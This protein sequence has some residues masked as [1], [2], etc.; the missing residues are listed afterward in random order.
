MVG[1]FP[2]VVLSALQRVLLKGALVP[3][4]ES[5]GTHT[6]FLV[7]IPLMFVAEQWFDER[8]RTTLQE[9]TKAVIVPPEEAFLIALSSILPMAP[10]L[11]FVLP[12][13]ELLIR[14]A[15]TLLGL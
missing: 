8:T 13:D 5:L 10:L 4:S 6:R 14:G 9:L 3:L 12:L 2:L 1:W 7:A 15:K 11:L